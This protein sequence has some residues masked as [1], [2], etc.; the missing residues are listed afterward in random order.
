M[1]ATM[2]K[3][4]KRRVLKIGVFGKHNPASLCYPDGSI[5]IT[6]RDVHHL[7]PE[8]PPKGWAEL[9]GDERKMDL[10]TSRFAAYVSNGGVVAPNAV[11]SFTKLISRALVRRITGCPLT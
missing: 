4:K 7:L 6:L 1:K 2:T 9:R 3:K 11:A 10:L 5:A 8:A